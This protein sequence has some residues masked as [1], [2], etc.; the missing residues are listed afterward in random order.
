M[1]SAERTI[2]ETD[3]AGIVYAALLG[4]ALVWAGLLFLP[5]RLMAQ[6]RLPAAALAYGAFSKL[7]HQHPDRSFHLDG[8]PLGV[9]ARCTGIYLG[10]AVGLLL[11]PLL[12]SPRGETFPD[13]KL[14]PL[15]ALPMAIDFAGGLI[16]LFANTFLSRSLT[17]G[18]FG[19]AA[20]FYILPGL[21]AAFAKRSRP[22]RVALP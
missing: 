5:P 2:S 13:R 7:C 18:L 4:L 17:G 1:V 22:R 15:A 16:G 6:G 20:A 21:V 11:L 3:R 9:C 12:R 19:M 14:L 8:F 10:F